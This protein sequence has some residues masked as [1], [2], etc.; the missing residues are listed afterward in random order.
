M[1]KDFT[2]Q[3]FKFILFGL[4]LFA[5]LTQ[6]SN[7]Q[8]Y[9]VSGSWNS[10]QNGTY[11]YSGTCN[12]FPYY[13]LGTNAL[14][15]NGYFWGIGDYSFSGSPCGGWMPFDYYNFSS[16]S[17]P[18]TSGWGNGLTVEIAAP[19]LIFSSTQFV[20]NSTNSGSISTSITI[21]HNNFGGA[22]FAGN[23][24]DNFVSGGRVAVYNI[25]SGMTA[26]IVRN[27]NLT[28]TFT[29]TGTAT[30]HANANDINNLNVVFDN[31][32][33]SNN[34]ASNT[35]NSNFNLGLNFIEVLTVGI[36]NTYATIQSAVNAANDFDVLSLGAQ[37]F[38]EP[39]IN[40]NNKSITILGQSPTQTIVQANASA[41]V[42][43]DRVFNISFS[44]YSSTNIVN[45]EKLTIRN[46]NAE[47]YGGGVLAWQV[48][49]NFLN[50]AVDSN[51]AYTTPPD[52][53]YGDGGGAIRVAD[54]SFS[55]TGTTFHNNRHNSVSNRP[56]DFMG[57]GA[58]AWFGQSAYG[59]TMVVTNCTFAN[60]I[61]GQYGAAILIRPT[62]ND[63]KIINST[64]NGNN[65]GISGGVAYFGGA[66]SASST[67]FVNS[68]FYGN[69]AVSSGPEFASSFSMTL[70]ATNCI[71]DNSTNMGSI[72]GNFVNCMIGQNP[73]LAAL[74]NN[75]GYTKT[76]ALASGSPA[77][78]AGTT[79]IDVP[80]TDQRGTST[81]NAKDI[82]SYEYCP[83]TSSITN[84]SICSSASPYTWNGVNYTTSGT[85][86]YTSTNS[87]GCDS[88]ATLNLSINVPTSSADSITINSSQLPYSWNGLTFN[89]A[90]TQT[91][92]L[93][94][95]AGCDSAA[96]LTLSVTA[97][98][99]AFHLKAMLQGLYL[100]NGKM[101]AA[102]FGANGVSP[103][104]IADTITVE[105]RENATPFNVIHTI[106]GLLDTAGNANIT[107]PGSVNGN[108]YYVVVGHRNSIA[109]WSASP[110]TISAST[111]YDFTNSISKA[112][113][114]NLADDGG[115]F[116]L[117]S[118][119]VN[120]DGSVDFS[121]YPD[122]DISSNNGDLGY[123][124]TDLNGDASVDFNDYPI[125]D[126]NSNL[127]VL[128]VTP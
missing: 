101:I 113:G 112:Y 62:D 49:V 103:M 95:A 73:L 41:G 93:T 77:I 25:P 48:N 124:V 33:F 55:A 67:N 17:T 86:I 28:L 69:T 30:A 29:L 37:T 51:Y 75:G 13:V 90:G 14:V 22:T 19:K 110:V 47:H 65:A 44:N 85:K 115:V 78:D 60:N 68:I 24:G 36:G 59:N 104:N 94:N 9:L 117:F 39:G 66:S 92:H 81:K 96:S 125:L 71:I 31:S 89:A 121:D 88:I 76:F 87:Q 106:K 107:F 116:M 99:I 27:D 111:T 43:S 50:C 56:G 26:S 4:I 100:G 34:N 109:V 108:S 120:Q 74:A 127:G 1:R 122:L 7:A 114:D 53:Y 79:S 64:F 42:A 21:T 118:G 102:P 57:G 58:V 128:V 46:G 5:G 35:V 119:D 8:N 3:V 40:I 15:N 38:T 20:E 63:I 6:K 18:P 84:I 23:N 105:L 45:F 72:S 126:I 11:V 82:G 97:S 32:A 54:G 123:Y 16:S 12:G 2:H 10:S 91:A 70:N 61:C 80:L 52:A 98:T 83:S